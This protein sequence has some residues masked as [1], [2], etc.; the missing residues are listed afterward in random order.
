MTA[1]SRQYWNE[2]LETLPWAEV[3]RWQTERIGPA[4]ERIRAGSA[5]YREMRPAIS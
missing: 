4:I 1:A 2:Q 5:M 3:E